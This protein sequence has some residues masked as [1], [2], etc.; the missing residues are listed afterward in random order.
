MAA[1]KKPK[2]SIKVG[3]LYQYYENEHNVIMV[4]EIT[5]YTKIKGAHADHGGEP[6]NCVEIS[7]LRGEK[8]YTV[9][10]SVERMERVW[11]HWF[12]KVG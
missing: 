11:S 4:Y 6:E 1:T 10:Y 2:V 5:Y 7:F 3:A 9:R 12:E 8:S